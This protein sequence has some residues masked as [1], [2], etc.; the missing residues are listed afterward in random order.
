MHLAWKRILVWG[1]VAF[2]ASLI[3]IY[4]V[5]FIKYDNKTGNIDTGR[6][7]GAYTCFK[8]CLSQEE[9]E[10]AQKIINNCQEKECEEIRILL[11]ENNCEDIKNWYSLN[12]KEVL[13]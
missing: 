11:N 3:V 1:S 13:P 2:V 7:M 5:L 10:R 12:K 9:E 6:F 4:I 8:T